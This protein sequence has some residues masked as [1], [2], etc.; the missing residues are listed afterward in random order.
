MKSLKSI[1]CLQVF[2]YKAQ[3]LSGQLELPKGKKDD[4][5]PIDDYL[6]LTRAELPE[7]FV[8]EYFNAISDILIPEY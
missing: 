8:P 6:W 1:I 5:A 7:Y 3:I 2:F 4:G